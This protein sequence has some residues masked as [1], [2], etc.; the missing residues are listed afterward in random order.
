M[1][2]HFRAGLRPLALAASFGV[3]NAVGPNQRRLS[4]PLRFMP[5]KSAKTSDL[6]IYMTGF[7]PQSRIQPQHFVRHLESTYSKAWCPKVWT[8]N[9]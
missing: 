4:G 9:C 5:P 2:S 1:T 7:D 8:K 3:V 6:T